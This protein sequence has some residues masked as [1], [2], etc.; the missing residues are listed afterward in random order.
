MRLS[1]STPR[2]ITRGIKRI[3]ESKMGGTLSS[4]SIIEDVD[5]ELKVFEIV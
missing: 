5:M 2:E 4:S 3:W 1:Y